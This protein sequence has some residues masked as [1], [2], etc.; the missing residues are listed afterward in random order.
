MIDN[1]FCYYHHPKKEEKEANLFA[2][3][4]NGSHK[5]EEEV[6]H[7]ESLLTHNQPEVALQQT[8]TSPDPSYLSSSFEKRVESWNIADS[9]NKL[10][11][12]Q[13]ILEKK[14]QPDDSDPWARKMESTPSTTTEDSSLTITSSS[15]PTSGSG[16]PALRKTKG[17]LLEFGRSHSLTKIEDTMTT[18]GSEMLLFSH[19]PVKRQMISASN[20]NSNFP[21]RT[22]T[23]A[24]PLELSTEEYAESEGDVSTSHSSFRPSLSNNNMK[25]ILQLRN[26]LILEKYLKQQYMRRVGSLFKDTTERERAANEIQSLVGF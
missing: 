5:T 2:F 26:E 12:I 15:P 3:N 20:N 19:A 25:Y 4:T 13:T 24:H 17:K 14:I 21:K 8:G 7:E 1:S 9:I 16:N 18:S 10:I 22:A 23:V 11:E 6:N